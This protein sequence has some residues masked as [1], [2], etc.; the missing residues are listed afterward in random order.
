GRQLVAQV[1]RRL[2]PGQSFAPLSTQLLPLVRPVAVC[3]AAVSTCPWSCSSLRSRQTKLDHGASSSSRRLST[4][5]FSNG[6]LWRGYP[7]NLLFHRPAV[8]VPF[9][10]TRSSPSRAIHGHCEFVQ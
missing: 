4:A 2:P 5:A 10:T 1:G 6:N 3:L 9:A 8:V 7:A